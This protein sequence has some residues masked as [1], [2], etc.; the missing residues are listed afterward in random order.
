[1]KTPVVI[2]GPIGCE[3]TFYGAEFLQVFDKTVLVGSVPSSAVI[4]SG[5]LILTT[6]LGMLD[7]LKNYQHPITVI[8]FEE[9]L[10][11]LQEAKKQE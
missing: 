10:F 6:F 8:S 11:I 3:K 2:Y 5:M 4:N 1:M 7:I 9:A